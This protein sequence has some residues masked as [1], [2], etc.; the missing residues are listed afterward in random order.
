SQ[1]YMWTVVAYLRGTWCPYANRQ[2]KEFRLAEER[3]MAAGG[4]IIGIVPAPPRQ[5]LAKVVE[6]ELG[7][8]LLAD[9]VFD[10]ARSFGVLERIEPG[11]AGPFLRARAAMIPIGRE[12]GY[13]VPRAAVW[14]IDP[15]GRVAA[16]WM[17]ERGAGFVE[18]EVLLREVERLRGLR[19]TESGR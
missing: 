7:F 18:A 5:L 13:W 16:E 12:E 2:L 17:R 15:E 6:L 10:A 14:V 1:L 11:E 8:V 19:G 4:T 3:L 9:E